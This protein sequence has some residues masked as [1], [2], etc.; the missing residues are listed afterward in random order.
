VLRRWKFSKEISGN[1]QAIKFPE[2]SGNFLINFLAQFWKFP[3]KISI[4]L[5]ILEWCAQITFY[6]QIT[7]RNFIHFLHF[8]AKKD[9]L[10]IVGTFCTLDFRVNSIFGPIT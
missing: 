7:F 10:G 2:I 5:D 3:G 4:Y 8:G 1:F 6:F 9:E